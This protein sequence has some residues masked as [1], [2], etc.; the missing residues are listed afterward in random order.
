MNKGRAHGKCQFDFGKD[1]TMLLCC[2]NTEHRVILDDSRRKDVLEE[3]LNLD[4]LVGGAKE[5]AQGITNKE[6]TDYN[7]GR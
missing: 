3:M 4:I 2:L 5:E 1:K 6:L 7:G